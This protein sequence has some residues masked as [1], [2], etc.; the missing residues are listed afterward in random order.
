MAAPMSAGEITPD[1]FI[2]HWAKAEASERANAQLFLTELADLLGVPRPSNSHA[3]GYSFEFPVKIPTGPGTFTDG[4][5]DLYR[6][7]CFVLEAKQFADVKAGP[8]ELA[9]ALDPSAGKRKPG[10]VRDTAA[11]DDAMWKARGQAERYARSLPADHPNAPFL[12]VV[13]VGHSIEVYADFTQAGRSYNHFPDPRSFRIR[14]ADLR[15]EQVRARLRRIWLDPLSLDPARI[16][17]A[18]TRE[19]AGY[20]ATLAS[21]LEDAGHQ[22]RLVAEFLTRCLFCMFAEDVGLLPKDGFRTLLESLRECESPA[23]FVPTLRQL[24]AEMQRGSDYSTLLRKKILH[25]NGGLFEDASVLPLDGTQL[26]ILIKAS[27]MQWKD[28]EPAIFG[29]LLERALDPGERHQLGAH[30]TPRAYVERLV[31]PTVIE[32][33]RAEWESVRAAAA[34]HAWRGDLKKARAEVNAFH[35]R[36]CAVTVLDPACGSGNFL[37]VALQHLKM[38]EGEVLDAA[39][40]FG[41]N[42][43]LELETHTIDPHQFLGIEKNERAAS[44]AELVLWIGYLQWHFKIHGQRTPPEPILRAFKNIQCRDAVLAWDG[45]P[46]EVTWEMALANPHLPGLPDDVRQKCGVADADA[47]SLRIPHSKFRTPITVWDRR[48]MKTDL[49]TG[50]DVPDE[51][52]RVPLLT[53]PGARPAA[54]PEADYIVGNPPF[55][56]T[57]RMREDLGDGYA[58]TLRAAYPEVP[59]S[60]DFVMYWWHKAAALTRTGAVRRFG[61]ITTNSLRQTFNRRVVEAHLKGNPLP[62]GGSAPFP[63]AFPPRLS[64]SGPFQNDPGKE[65]NDPV[66]SLSDPVASLSDPVASLNEPVASLNEPVASLNEPVASLSEP[67]ASPSGPVASLND[68]VASL[69]DPL[70]SLN[71]PLASLNEPLASL[72]EPLPQVN[73]SVASLK[74][75]AKARKP[76]VKAKNLSVA[77]PAGP[78][79]ALCLL[80]AIPDHP[81]VD[82]AEGAAVRIAMTVGAAGEQPGELRTVA[83]EEPHD[84]GSSVVTLT[85]QTGRIAADLTTGADVVGIVPLKA[86]EGLSTPGVKLHG[87]GFIVTPEMAVALGLGT[88]PGLEDYIRHYRHGKDLNDTPRGVMVIDLHGL[89]AEDVRRRFPAVYQHVLTAVKPERDHNNEAYRRENWWLFGRKNTELRAA[90]CGL[91]RYIATAETSKHRMFQFLDASIRPDNMLIAIALDDAFHLG[92]L[93]SRIHVVFALAAGGR[94]GVGNDPR[95]NKTRCFDPFP[96]PACDETAKARIRALGEELDAHRKRVQ[97]QHPGLSLTAMYN[98]FE[99]LRAGRALTPKEQTTHDTGLVSLLRQLHDELDAAVAAAYGWPAGQSDAE[100]LTHLVA[101]NAARAAEEADGRVRWLRPAYQAPTGTGTTQPGLSLPAA[102]AKKAQGEGRKAKEPWPKPLAERVAA[103]ERALQTAASPATPAQLAKR[104]LRAK[105]ADLAEILETLA[106]LGRAHR[107]GGKYS[108]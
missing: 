57:S 99:A 18:V 42:F 80:F 25:F 21:S 64:D 81:W 66:A 94:L 102:A 53:Y 31:L 76:S 16:S 69:N 60:A 27:T 5:L 105:P 51:T 36:L 93:S 41:E 38:L 32:P 52:Q 29:T 85:A 22:P 95:Y 17:A 77:L 87:A 67:V 100:I 89:S 9:L 55:L 72:N 74:D 6:R 10:T 23:G 8:T 103:V 62:P 40:Q 11:W 78:A 108:A 59:E 48:S 92:V 3:D 28:V 97:A 84:D 106:T 101:L 15:D 39:A 88:V 56:G 12:L 2:A 50:R 4:R 63:G 65:L 26:G 14:L 19:I 45:H 7:G 44:I 30:Y 13:D 82:T 79:P 49:V 20:L 104:F 98:V 107:D 54:W 86:N 91:P 35:D 43:K 90:L 47:T 46:V 24:F 68:P 71:D 1:T 96:F 58:E 61:L 70:A 37:Y 83:T 33:L 34:T 75:A 73:S